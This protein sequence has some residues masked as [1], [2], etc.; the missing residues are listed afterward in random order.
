MWHTRKELRRNKR[1][2]IQTAENLY[3]ENGLDNVSLNTIISH[4]GVS[5]GSFYS[6]YD[7]KDSLEAEFI[8][9]TI[10]S[11][12][13]SYD[14][15]LDSFTDQASTAVIFSSLLEKVAHNITKYL[16]YPLV[17][18]AGMIQIRKSNNY[19]ILMTFSKGLYSAVYKLVRRGIGQ[20]EF[21][22]SDSA[23]TIA[24]NIVMCIRGFIFEWIIRYPDMDLKDCLQKHFRVY[25]AGL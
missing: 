24:D 19:A 10:S 12:E 8:N 18:T 15:I 23:E 3:K 25:F 1:N 20:G 13:L 17:K 11:M 22:T 9:D 7:S 4:A 2:N 21:R 14:N 5:K 16:G 6:H